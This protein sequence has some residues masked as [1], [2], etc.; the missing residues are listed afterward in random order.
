[1][2]GVAAPMWTIG[3]PDYTPEGKLVLTD[4]I[5]LPLRYGQNVAGTRVLNSPKLLNNGL[6]SIGGFISV[7]GDKGKNWFH[8]MGCFSYNNGTVQNLND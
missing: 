3:R 6:Y 5:P 4:Y 2:G 1:M 8:L 7:Y